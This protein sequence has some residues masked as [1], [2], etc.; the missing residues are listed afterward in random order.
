MVYSYASTKFKYM[1][2]IIDKIGEIFF[3]SKTGRTGRKSYVFGYILV[4]FI[5]IF[6]FAIVFIF[7]TDY[8]TLFFS[9]ISLLLIP[10]IALVLLF[11]ELFLGYL[12]AKRQHDLGISSWPIMLSVR[13]FIQKG[14]KGTNQYGKDPS[15]VPFFDEV[16]GFIQYY[17]EHIR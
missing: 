16:S 13:K 14:Q 11:C 7:V 5:Q 1:K 8:S 6:I 9:Y 2:I 4:R 12:N 10:F 3:Y 17:Q 15:G